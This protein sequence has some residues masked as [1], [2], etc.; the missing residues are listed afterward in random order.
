MK[1]RST[2]EEIIVK[3]KRAEHL[4]DL[5]KRTKMGL[6]APPKKYSKHPDGGAQAWVVVGGVF[7]AYGLAFG[8]LRVFSL[9]LN[10][11]R[12]Y[13]GVSSTGLFKKIKKNIILTK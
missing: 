7:I 1:R 3:E 8:L 2:Y 4:R 5:F 10:P 12:A 6:F 13:Y 9:L 11:I